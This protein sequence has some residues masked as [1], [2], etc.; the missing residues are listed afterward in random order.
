MSWKGALDRAISRT[1]APFPSVQRWWTRKTA[2]A[3]ARGETPWAPFERDFA[4]SRIAVLTT[5]GFR[6]EDQP[7]FDCDRG[8]PSFREIP[9]DVDLADLVVDHTHYDT[10]NA[11]EDP[12]IVLPLDRLRELVDEGS[13]GALAPTHYSMMGYVPETTVLV[14]DTAPEIAEKMGSEE[15]DFALLTPA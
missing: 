1:I 5:G 6:F 11:E 9:S 15:V 13:L 8:D 3:E 2:T 4:G 14:E 7:A 12:N 10:R